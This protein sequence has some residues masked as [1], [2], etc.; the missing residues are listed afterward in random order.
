MECTDG[1]DMGCS[2]CE[3]G[4][5]SIVLE[6]LSI[7][8]STS[9]L[10]AHQRQSFNHLQPST[11]FKVSSFNIQPSPWPPTTTR[12]PLSER[13]IPWNAHSQETPALHTPRTRFP[14]RPQHTRKSCLTTK[15]QSPLKHPTRPFLLSKR[16]LTLMSRRSTP[17]ERIR[18]RLAPT[19]PV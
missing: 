19:A 13:N 8:T 11:R 3:Q 17:L 6:N 10:Q 2:V 16:I 7:S 12:N 4:N 15:T 1:R 5:T 14:L 9:T 18:M